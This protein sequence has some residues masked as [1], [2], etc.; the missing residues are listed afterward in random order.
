M[1]PNVRLL[2]AAMLASILVLIC[3]FGVFAAFRVSRE[4]IAHL[5]ATMA[6]LQLVAESRAASSTV[7]VA[8]ETL[9]QQSL[10]DIPVSPSEETATPRGTAE[11]RDQAE[12]VAESEQTAAPQPIA[13]M[14]A[15]PDAAPEPEKEAAAMTAPADQPPTPSTPAGDLFAPVEGG[16]RSPDIAAGA[17][18]APSPLRP[19]EPAAD[20]STAT[21][22]TATNATVADAIAPNAIAPN[23]IPPNAIAPNAKAADETASGESTPGG[24]SAVAE[25]PLGKTNAVTGPESEPAAVASVAVEAMPD[26]AL[27]RSEHDMLP[28]PPLPRS[29]P[30]ITDAKHVR[31]AQPARVADERVRSVAVY[32]QR[33]ARIVV[34]SV[35]AVRFTAPYYAQAQYAQNIDQ[36]YGYGQSNFQGGQEQIAVRRVV[37]LHAARVAARKTNAAIGGPFVRAPSP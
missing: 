17:A 26:D 24:S 18:S 29:R 4:P 8:R 22:D 14:D 16:D 19:I 27:D 6:P 5:P 11:Q 25:V 1:F 23:A 20:Q 15:E 30:T 2:I 12:P 34:R 7:L 21:S 10:F 36:A 13:A 31:H 28:E 33:R 9:S 35:R 32:R 3:G 37:R